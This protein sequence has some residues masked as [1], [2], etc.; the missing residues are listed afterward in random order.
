MTANKF[1][2]ALLGVVLY[3]LTAFFGIDTTIITGGVFESIVAFGTAILVYFV[4]NKES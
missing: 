2:V 4:P 1:V 3:A